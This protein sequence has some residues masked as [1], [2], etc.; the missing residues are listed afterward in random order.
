MNLSYCFIFHFSE[1]A[2]SER[3]GTDKV[4]FRPPKVIHV[5]HKEPSIVVV[6][7]CMHFC[8]H[9]KLVTCNPISSKFQ[10]KKDDKDQEKIQSSS[11]PDPGYHKG[12]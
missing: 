7:L 6:H 5:L 2:A 12:K 1:A 9:Y 11:T 10:N 8:G 4:A 3:Q